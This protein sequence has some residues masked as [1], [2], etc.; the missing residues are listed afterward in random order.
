MLAKIP[1]ASV[2]GID[3]YLAT[4]RPDLLPATLAATVALLRLFELEKAVYEI[5]Y[6]LAHRPDWV[7]V[8]VAGLR[9]LLDH[10]AA[11]HPDPAPDAEAD[12]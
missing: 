6:E 2:I 4:V 5:G 9:R 10:P 1:S 8:P 12:R 11:P 3:G 7:G